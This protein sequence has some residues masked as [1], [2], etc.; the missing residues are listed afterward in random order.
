MLKEYIN[1]VKKGDSLSVQESEKCLLTILDNE[2]DDNQIAD[3]LIS[4]AEKGESKNEVIGFS[5]ILLSK[6][7][8]LKLDKESIDLCGTGGSGLNRFNVSTTSSFILASG[9]V[10]VIKHGN[11]GSQKP[12]GS[13]DLLD[14][15]KCNYDLKEENQKKLF[16]STNLTFIFARKYHPA[17]KKVVNARKMA[18]RRTIFNI[19]GPLCNPAKPNYQIIGT[20]DSKKAKLIADCLLEMSKKRCLVVLGEPGIDEISISGKTSIYKIQDN[21]INKY[22]LDPHK[23]NINYTEYSKIPA[24]NADENISILNS[25]LNN[26]AP[27]SIKDMVCLNSGAAFYCYG[28]TENI[29]EGIEK[30]RSLLKSGTVK[31]FVDNYISES[32]KLD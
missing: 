24:G 27:E 32:N 8:P 7:L 20:T 1:K 28:K 22:K 25:L 9:G 11:K 6:T 21:T 15:L 23:F 4:L 12:N 30:S 18:K 3:F 13:F 10:K 17:M 5:N 31:E 29:K 19:I 14:E 2:V 16:N 26:T